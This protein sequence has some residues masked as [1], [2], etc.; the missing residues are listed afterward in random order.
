MDLKIAIKKILDLLTE[1]SRKLVSYT[2]VIV[3][4]HTV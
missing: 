1:C 3:P 4:H 2:A